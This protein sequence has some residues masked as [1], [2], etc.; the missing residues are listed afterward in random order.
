MSETKNDVPTTATVKKAR[1][2]Y[3]SQKIILQFQPSV[4]PND[5]PYEQIAW[6]KMIFSYIQP[7]DY[8][9]LRLRRLCNMFKASLKAPPHGVFTKYPHSNHTSIDSLFNRCKELYD[10]DPTK[11]PTIFFIKDGVH[12]IQGYYEEHEPEHE[13]DSDYDPEDYHV[14][15]RLIQYPMQ[16]IGAG[17]DKTTLCGGG[18][19]I[20]GTKEEGKNVVLKDMT[21]SETKGSGLLND[22][23]LSFLCKRMT[24]IQCGASGVYVENTKGRFINCV[25]TQCG[26]NGIYCSMNAL[27]EL[28]GDQTKVHGNGTSGFSWYYGLRTNDTSSTIHLLFPLTEE[29]VS[30]NNQGGGNYG[31]AGT[32]QTV[33]SFETP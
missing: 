21:I 29:S 26:S 30:T 31:G 4:D 7:N 15:W 23:G 32:I 33:D 17:R 1:Y 6:W 16:I 3:I 5:I 9:R 22:N 18:L 13:D 20:E 11:A 2:S 28:E 27:I 19:R 25:I 12:E 8:E 14:P 10:E 24:F